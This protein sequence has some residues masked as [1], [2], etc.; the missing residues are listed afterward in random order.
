M[1]LREQLKN[2]R[3][4]YNMS[5]EELSQKMNVTRQSV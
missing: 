5:R 4:Q 3:E 1:D 2:L